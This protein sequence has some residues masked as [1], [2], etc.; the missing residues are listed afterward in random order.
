VKIGINKIP[1]EGL[2]LEEEVAPGKLDLETEIVKFH[3]PLKI[4]AHVLKITNAITVDLG[5]TA[6][7]SLSC[8][9]CLREFEVGLCKNLK[10]NYAVDKSEQ[11][12]DLDPDIREEI[13]LDYPIK[14]LCSPG[15]KGLC[16]RCGNDL[17]EGECSC[18]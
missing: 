15:C 2:T 1:P 7:I 17:N 9:R 3:S 8:S 13:I 6:A 11:V 4:E 16:P 18:N 10:L 12:I 5:L 14:P